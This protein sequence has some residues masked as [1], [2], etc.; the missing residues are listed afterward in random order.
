MEFR[1]FNRFDDLIKY[2]EAWNRL[3]MS[4]AS[5]VPFLT[6]EYL[7]TWWETRGG[8]EWPDE[9]ELAIAAAFQ[10]QSLIGAAPL[11]L[12]RNDRG[13]ATIKFVGAVEVSDFL[14]FII[15]PRDL[16]P[17]TSDL[18][19]FLMNDPSIPPWDS[20][21]LDNLLDNSPTLTILKAE[22]EHRGWAFSQVHLQPSPYVKLPGDFQTYLAGL[23]KKQRHEIRRKIRRIESSPE[24][25]QLTFT[26]S[27]Q[28]LEADVN[29]FIDMMA[30]DPNKH[31]FLTD[32][33]RQ[34]LHKTAKVAFDHGWLQLS[35]L[36]LN[37]SKAAAHMSFVY[38]DRI[39][40][41]NS[42]WDWAYRE[43][44]PGWVLLAYLLQ[45]ATENGI[46][47]FDFM[48]GDEPYKY[49][50]GGVDRHV[51]RAILSRK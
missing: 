31:T 36:T 38:N 7:Q 42:G 39:W 48:R 24:D 20:I 27:A 9:S 23:D 10:G 8:G 3:V 26:Q 47:V 5:Q 45:W 33:M 14:D 30:Q 18:L 43:F 19:D 51:F 13:Q 49:K 11:F 17:F 40:L 16:H 15:H 6:F 34:H 35:F 2:K 32:P 1:R 29:A 41:Y 22:V 4:S 44:S 21:E 50:F 46:Q 12:A 28:D 25:V 37:G